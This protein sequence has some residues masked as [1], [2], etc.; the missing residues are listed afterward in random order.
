MIPFFLPYYEQPHWDIPFPIIGE[1][2]IHAFGVLVA[3]AL[4][5]GTWVARWHGNSLKQNPTHVV[6]AVTWTAITG[7]VVAHLVSVIFYFPERL[8]EDPLQL[9]MI[10]NGLSSFGG[11]LGGVLGAYFFLKRR[12]LPILAYVDSIAV[13]L[14]VGWVLGRLGCTVAHDH[15]GLPTDFFLAFDHPRHGPIHDLG[16]YEFLFTLVLFTVVM[17]LRRRKPP[18]GVIPAVMAILYSPVRF[19]FDFLRVQDAK[20]LGLTPGQWSAV[21]L[22]IGGAVLLRYAL[23]KNQRPGE[24]TE[25]VEK[26]EDDEAEEEKS[27]RGDNE[28]SGKPSR[29]TGKVSKNSKQGKRKKSST[30]KSDSDSDDDS[31][32]R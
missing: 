18:H 13:G 27:D 8:I 25:V 12:G 15:P 30:K 10:W 19:F 21:A 7:F 5:V 24:A 2:T 31:S 9:V 23:K 4:V 32:D 22:L 20:Y 29:K 6:D 14:S 26:V 3:L 16:F 11:F 28:D 17:I 1:L